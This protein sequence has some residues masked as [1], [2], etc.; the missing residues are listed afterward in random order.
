[1]S[2]I[3]AILPAAGSALRMRG[4][5]KFMLPCSQDYETLIERHVRNLLPLVDTIWIPTRPEFAHLIVKLGFGSKVIVHAIE[6]ET[7]SETILEVTRFAKAD[8]FILCMPDTYF[9]K[10]L[11][12]KHLADSTSDLELT[13]F[14]IRPDQKG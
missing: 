7:M 14:K 11:P 10:D 1:M 6:T 3:S 8:R 9:H 4:L 5:P 12:Y 2:T 13:V